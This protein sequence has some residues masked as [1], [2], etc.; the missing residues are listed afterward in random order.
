MSHN[1]EKKKRICYTFSNSEFFMYVKLSSARI[2]TPIKYVSIK[3]RFFHFKQ[4]AVGKMIKN[5]PKILLLI[6]LLY[7]RY[8][9]VTDEHS[10]TP[11]SI[12]V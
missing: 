9:G 2:S 3:K 4:T 12:C 6:D 1:I 11:T 7:Y 10:V 5:L 8:T